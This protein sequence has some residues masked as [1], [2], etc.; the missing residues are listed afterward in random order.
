MDLHTGAPFWL[1]RNGFGTRHTALTLAESC[2]VVVWSGTFGETKD[3]LPRIGWLPRYPRG[4]FALGLG[5]NGITFS[6]IA[7]QTICDLC[8][9]LSRPDALIF[10]PDR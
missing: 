8:R 4:L 6:V 5:G 2:D 3:S 9:G 7:S 10:R 1:I